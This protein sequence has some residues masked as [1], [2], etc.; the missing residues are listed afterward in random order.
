MF[1]LLVPASEFVDF[2]EKDP[3]RG[4]DA[5]G[6][7]ANGLAKPVHDCREPACDFTQKLLVESYEEDASGV[8]APL[9]EILN[10]LTNGGG[11][12]DLPGPAQYLND[13][14]G[15]LEPCQ[16][17]TDEGAPVSRRRSRT[18]RPR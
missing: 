18:D 10:E 4:F 3:R 9:E 7:L 13:A 2:V 1:D 6:L 16:E 12:P 15:P 5:V 8:G 11:F 17:V 14:F